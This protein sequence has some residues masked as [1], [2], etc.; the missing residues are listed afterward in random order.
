MANISTLST[1]TISP[2]T[3]TYTHTH[4]EPGL[5]SSQIH[6]Y[7]WTIRGQCCFSSAPPAICCLF[8]QLLSGVK[9]FLSADL[10]SELGSPQQQRR[11]RSGTVMPIPVSI[12]TGT[13]KRLCWCSFLLFQH[14]DDSPHRC[15]RCSALAVIDNS[16]SG[17][18]VFVCVC[19]YVGGS[20]N[21][22][23]TCRWV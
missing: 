17:R 23:V 14:E 1:F 11:S 3:H 4:T 22:C 6:R 15:I 10:G 20:G 7:A 19:V 5:T 9:S 13:I 21:V 16:P 2:Q 8:P 18:C 12:W